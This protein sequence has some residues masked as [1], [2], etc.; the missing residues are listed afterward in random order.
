M[1]VDLVLRALF[2]MT[3]AAGAILAIVLLNERYKDEIAE[4]NRDVL[5]NRRMHERIWDP[6]EADGH[7]PT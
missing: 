2:M 5:Q 6:D 7:Q 1:D 3:C 4:I